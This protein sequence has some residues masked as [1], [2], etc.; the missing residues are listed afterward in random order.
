VYIYV[1]IYIYIYKH[2]HTY[3][4][5]YE[6]HV[7]TIKIFYDLFSF[8]IYKWNLY[9]PSFEIFISGHLVYDAVTARMTLTYRRLDTM[10]E[11][12]S[13]LIAMILTLLFNSLLFAI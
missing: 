10:L 5:V 3:I 11:K 13:V 1:Y 7:K 8:N 4:Y 12:Y 9:S 6:T 2:T